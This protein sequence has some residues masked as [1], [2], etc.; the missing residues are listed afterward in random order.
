MTHVLPAIASLF[1][2]LVTHALQ[3]AEAAAAAPPESSPTHL[4]VA[5]GL[6]ALA[7]VFL[8]AEFFI[9]SGGLLGL[10]TL[11]CAVGSVISMFLWSQLAGLI[12][13]AALLVL[14]PVIVIQGVKVWSKTPIGKRAVL[15]GEAG[16]GPVQDAL[17]PELSPQDGAA[18]AGAVTV[19]ARG[20][21]ETPLRPGGF[22]RFG[23][24][25]VDAVAEGRFID[26]GEQVEVLGRV[27]AQWRVRRIE[28]D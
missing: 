21:A 6:L 2:S 23:R 1:P 14:G 26:A 4:L 9:P 3:T 22:V 27:E 12:L 11:L 18:S 5:L 7:L 20:I 16:G 8:V 28:G 10:L 13:M 25:R 19:G 24:V 15:H 17:A